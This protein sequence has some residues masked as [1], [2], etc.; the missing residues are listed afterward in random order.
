MRDGPERAVRWVR[1]QAAGAESGGAQRRAPM[2][3]TLT[4]SEAISVVGP[5]AS[6][7]SLKLG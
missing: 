4:S 2:P 5:G 1:G 3:V 6:D 7:S